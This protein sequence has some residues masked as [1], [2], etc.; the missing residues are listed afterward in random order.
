MRR[1]TQPKEDGAM[2]HR[3]NIAAR[4]GRWSAQHR[5]TA[6]L[7]WIAF[8]VIAFMIGGKVGTQ[9]LT[10]EQSGVGESGQAARIASEAYPKTV[11]E[12][13]L[14]SSKTLDADAPEFRAAVA[15]VTQRLH[16]TDGVTKVVDPYAK[17]G[18]GGVS[19]DDHAAMIG[20]E[21][22]GERTSPAVTR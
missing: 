14:V 4:A 10:N 17:R 2:R 11:G 21:I 18:L 19:P 3:R 16:K 6:I 12:A 15:D 7:G 8:V 20:F 9:T 22:A 1:M 13:V 5:K